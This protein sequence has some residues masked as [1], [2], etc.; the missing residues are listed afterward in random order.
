MT[1]ARDIRNSRSTTIAACGVAVGLG[2]SLWLWR[3]RHIADRDE[4]IID[5]NP[6]LAKQMRATSRGGMCMMSCFLCFYLYCI[7]G[8]F[9]L[10][11]ADGEAGE[12]G[13]ESDLVLLA[14]G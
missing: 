2:L 13:K 14:C 11:I 9:V 7:F 12:G 1:T 10:L 4:R 8:R 6:N 5:Y 3:R